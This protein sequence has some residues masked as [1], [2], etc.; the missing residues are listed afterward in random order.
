MAS[1]KVHFIVHD[2][3]PSESDQFG[4]GGTICG[5]DYADDATDRPA[6]VTCKNCLKQLGK[7]ESNAN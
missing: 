3:M 4:D 6:A 7:G 1:R 5:L 2:V